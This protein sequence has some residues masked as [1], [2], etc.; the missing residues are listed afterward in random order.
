MNRTVYPT[1]SHGGQDFG[2]RWPAVQGNSGSLGAGRPVSIVGAVN[3]WQMRPAINLVAVGTSGTCTVRIQC[4]GAAV[5]AGVPDAN[6]WIDLLTT[7]LT[8]NAGETT[9]KKILCSQPYWRTV[10]V[11]CSGNIQFS[12]YVPCIHLWTPG[13]GIQW[14]SAGY[15]TEDSVGT[16]NL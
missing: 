13:G 12:S 7:P 16:A 10:L 3:H 6:S 8:L 15:P 9:A 14:A 2:T 11:T 1:Y 5:T 4:N